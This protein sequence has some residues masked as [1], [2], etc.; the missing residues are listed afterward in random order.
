MLE[1]T[2]VVKSTRRH[3]QRFGMSAPGCLTVL[4]LGMATPSHPAVADNG[5]QVAV[6]S[7]ATVERRIL[8]EA[9]PSGTVVLRG[10]RPVEPQPVTL[11]PQSILA[12]SAPFR[13]EGWD[14]DY[15]TGG[16]NRSYDTSGVDLRS[17]RLFDT[18]GFDRGFDRSGLGR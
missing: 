15:D 14:P 8:P 18:T 13:P 7:P 16:I 12:G 3:I 6:V 1:R 2:R 10:S 11:L 4:V 17:D 5:P 9:T